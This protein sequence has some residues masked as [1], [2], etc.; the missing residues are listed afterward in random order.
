MQSKWFNIK[1]YTEKHYWELIQQKNRKDN[2]KFTITSFRL[3][4]IIMSKLRLL[5]N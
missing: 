2:T 4:D 3:E 5:T 1:Y